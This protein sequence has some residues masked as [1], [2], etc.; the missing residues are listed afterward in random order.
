M[1][2]KAKQLTEHQLFNRMRALCKDQ[3]SMVIIR[4]SMA[5]TALTLKDIDNPDQL[6]AAVNAIRT[7]TNGIVNGIPVAKP[8]RQDYKVVCD[9][10]NNPPVLD[11]APPP[12]SFNPPLI[13]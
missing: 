9:E 3:N 6:F 8:E 4:S 10:T 5:M 11:D 13:P 1:A 7:I 12:P 2:T